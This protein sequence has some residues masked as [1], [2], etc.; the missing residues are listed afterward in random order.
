MKREENI[1]LT[2]AAVTAVIGMVSIGYGYAGA[3]M[4]AAGAVTEEELQAIEAKFTQSM[5]AVN[6]GVQS[7]KEGVAQTQ[8]VQVRHADGLKKVREWLKKLH[9]E[10]REVTSEQ[11]NEIG[12][13]IQSATEAARELQD[14]LQIAAPSVI[15]RLEEALA[16]M[17]GAAADSVKLALPRITMDERGFMARVGGKVVNVDLAHGPGGA[18]QICGVDFSGAD[19]RA[20]GEMAGAAAFKREFVRCKTVA[21]HVPRAAAPQGQVYG[22]KA[23]ANETY[24]CESSDDVVVVMA[25]RYHFGA[26]HGV[27]NI[28]DRPQEQMVWSE[29]IGGYKWRASGTPVAD[30]SDVVYTNVTTPPPTAHTGFVFKRVSNTNHGKD[31][32][33]L[34]IVLGNGIGNVDAV[35]RVCTAAFTKFKALMPGRTIRMPLNE[36][37][38]TD[39]RGDVDKYTKAVTDAADAAKTKVRVYQA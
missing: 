13:I 39:P 34:F 24:K 22:E 20:A 14:A 33:F 3:G 8:A 31:K 23:A 17:K 2:L 37:L 18:W 25:T 5:D 16:G 32:L 21:P 1:A 15:A 10:K 36:G 29:W 35:K 12:V 27:R 19:K 4:G 38:M 9:D 7:I 11:I 26:G 30:E 28:N 6:Q